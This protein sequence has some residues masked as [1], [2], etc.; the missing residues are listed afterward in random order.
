MYMKAHAQTLPNRTWK[1]FFPVNTP[2]LS[3]EAG[4]VTN[5]FIPGE[6]KTLLGSRA[7]RST[8]AE[9]PKVLQWVYD[10]KPKKK[11]IIGA[12]VQL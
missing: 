5:S 9:E 7:E 11:K 6:E 1:N 10:K 4:Q 12:Y 2:R 8:E 3:V